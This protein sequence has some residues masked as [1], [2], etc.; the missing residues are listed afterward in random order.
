MA[1]LSKHG[2][3]VGPGEELTAA[4]L[5]TRLPDDWIIVANKELPAPNSSREVDFIVVGSKIIFYIEEKHWWG[6]I[7]GNENGWVL[8]SGESYPSPLRKLEEVGKRLNAFLVSAAPELASLTGAR[9]SAGFVL[10]SHP[11]ARAQIDDPRAE[12]HVHM[13]DGCEEALKTR[14]GQQPESASIA[15]YRGRIID[16]LVAMPDRPPVPHRLGAYQISDVLSVG[17]AGKVLLGRHEDGTPRILKLVPKPMTAD[18]ERKRQVE[19]ALL[20]EYTALRRLADMGV[21]PKVDPYLYWDQ[22]QFWIFPIHPVEGVTLAADRLS[23]EPTQL[24]FSGVAKAAFTALQQVHDEGILHRGLTPNRVWI[25]LNGSAAFSD[26]IVARIEGAST[27]A[28]EVDQLDPGNPFRAP[29]TFGNP[30]FATPA[31]DVYGLAASLFYWLTG[32]DFRPERRPPIAE[33]RLGLGGGFSSS[34]DELFS[35]CLAGEPSKRPDMVEVLMRLDQL[36]QEPGS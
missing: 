9:F 28:S 26:F 24:V 3:F 13:L 8:S 10:L 5:E 12:G 2:E 4:H 34:V 25:K 20:R 31:S 7:R 30:A 21:A 29:E 33:L 35:A 23:Q 16:R 6:P 18:P 19:E 36:S 15:P 32:F 14:D 11:D 27:I 17:G 22:E 1:R